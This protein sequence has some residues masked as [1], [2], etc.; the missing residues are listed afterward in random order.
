MDDWMELNLNVL[1]GS[2]VL[3]LCVSLLT[4]LHDANAA[5]AIHQVKLGATAELEFGK[6]VEKVEC[7]SSDHKHEIVNHDK[8]TQYAHEHYGDRIK[9]HDGKLTIEHVKKT[10]LNTFHYE[11]NG[12]PMAITLSEEH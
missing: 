8:L 6:N 10:D 3:L 5:A 2:W 4:L 7:E 11:L 12:K 1:K 9:W